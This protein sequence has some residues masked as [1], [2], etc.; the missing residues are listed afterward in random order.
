MHQC[1]L[2]VGSDAFWRAAEPDIR[3]AKSRLFV[4]AMTFEADAA[5]AAVGRA[6][7]EST[8]ADRRVLVDHYTRFVVNDTFVLSPRAWFD[9]ELRREVQATGAMFRS[10]VSAG[11]GVRATNPVGPLLVRYGLRNHK[12]L[13]VADN[14][15]Y[16]GGVNFSD[17]N[18][19]WHDLMLR[20]EG[21]EPA[22]FLAEDILATYDGRPVFRQAEFG[23]IKLYALDGRTNRAGFADVLGVIAG[24]KREICVVSPYLTFP[25]MAPLRR[26][27]ERGVGVQ[28]ITPL[29][30]NKPLVKHY[31]LHSAAEA[32]FDV[33]LVPEMT[34]LKGILADGKTLVLGSSNF[35]FA[36]FHVEEELVAIAEDPVLVESF[37]REVILP[38]LAHAAVAGADHRSPWQGRRSHAVLRVAEMLVKLTGGARRTATEWTY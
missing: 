15:A 17:H 9:A 31:L 37:R 26:A 22:D 1:E 13:I 36:S 8:A 3:G 14:V 34:H 38:A 23:A 18:F 16:L 33:R 30:N 2:L 21:K 20:I 24:A 29:P 35:D 19:A 28:L 32:G 27:V 4:Q 6:I 11:V 25:F 10:L 7:A 5:G 12:K